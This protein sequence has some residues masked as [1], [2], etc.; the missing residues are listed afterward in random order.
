MANLKDVVSKMSKR[1]DGRNF[2]SMPQ[3]R[4][5]Q[6]K[7]GIVL[8]EFKEGKLKSSSGSKVTNIKQAVAIAISEARRA[9]KK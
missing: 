1:R 4:P 9:K 7:I 6:N 5:S 8:S 3:D 2:E